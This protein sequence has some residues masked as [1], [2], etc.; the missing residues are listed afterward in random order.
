MTYIA[1]F[2]I[3]VLSAPDVL[4][5]NQRVKCDI[6]GFLLFMYVTDTYLVAVLDFK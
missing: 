3:S 4:N 2:F 1:N 6:A 5:E